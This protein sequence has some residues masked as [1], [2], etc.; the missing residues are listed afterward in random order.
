MM[1]GN[2]NIQF[3]PDGWLQRLE[4]GDKSEPLLELAANIKAESPEFAG[5]SSSF[6]A[7]LR[8]QLNDQ[9]TQQTIRGPVVPHW[10]VLGFAILAV[11]AL[12]IVGLQS[13]PGNMPSV[14]AAEILNLAS[15]HMATKNTQDDV[16]Y[17]RLLLDWEKGSLRQ[18]GVVAELWRSSDGSQLRY[19]MYAG[20]HL[21]YFDQH[22]S[23]TVW[24][25]SHIRPVEG[26]TVDFVYQADY[27]PEEISIADT[28]LMFQLLFRD[29]ENFWVYIDRLFG[30]YNA[31][32]ENPFCV[33][34]ALGDDW[35]C[36]I[37]SCTLNL[38]Q[39]P[40]EGE[41]IIEA[42]VL[43]D[44]WLSNG[45]QVH[46][47]RLHIAGVDDRY[48]QILKFD[49][50]TFDLLEIED[51]SGGK[52]QYRIR[53]V[54]RQLL[55]WSD[56]PEDFFQAI[57]DGVEVRNWDSDYPLGHRSLDRVWVISADPPPGAY[58]TEPFSA[59]VELGYRLT[60]LEKAA[61][62]IG[63]LNWSGHDTRV[64]IDVEEVVVDAGEGVVEFD[65]VVDTTDLG[66]GKWV[67]WPDFRDILGIH[68]GPGIGWNSFGIPTG[69]YPE[70]CIRCQ[71]PDAD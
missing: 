22:D 38:G 44:D 21:L 63:G 37:S 13:L 15:Q 5:P 61:I 48:Y 59:H 17:D 19:Q 58:L 16:L 41:L 60:S 49:T 52:L 26:E 69:I 9:F 20:D 56:L 30:G 57:P 54:D 36:D 11:I 24:R 14:S 29:L 3:D 67:I 40:L 47:V 65:F 34:S 27:K 39:V 70:W 51:Y 43:E 10:F 6:K 66:D 33:L 2:G 23:E 28:Q 25:S 45:H 68:L 50:T 31:D 32:C 53:L 7:K 8:A 35:V 12:V 64:K 62:N 55:T 46:Q 4:D 1:I 18:Q 42:K 71:D